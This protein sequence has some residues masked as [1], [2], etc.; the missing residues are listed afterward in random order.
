MIPE[1]PPDYEEDPDYYDRLAEE[2]FR[3]GREHPLSREESVRLITRVATVMKESA[4]A[5]GDVETAAKLAD[6]ERVAIDIVDRAEE[7]ERRWKKAH[8][9]HT[10]AE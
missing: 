5:R 8:D 4:E 1:P 6:P 7:A 3:D 9:E 2:V 10:T